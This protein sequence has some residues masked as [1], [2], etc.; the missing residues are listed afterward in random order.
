MC[1]NCNSLVCQ[2]CID[3]ISNSIQANNP[4]NLI[5]CIDCEQ[6]LNI[7][8]ITK[9]TQKGLDMLHVQ[10]P[11]NNINCFQEFEL[12]DILEHLETCKYYEG[13]SR[14]SGCGFIDWTNKVKNH[15]KVCIEFLDECKYCGEYFKKKALN[16]HEKTCYKRPRICKLCTCLID[17]ENIHLH[18]SKDACMLNFINEVKSQLESNIS[19][20]FIK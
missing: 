15:T 8:D 12:K 10:C 17:E 3:S 11:S 2:I 4:E 18:P 5:L 16:Q 19:P 7:S 6:V 14:C 20:F 13:K 1:R 9:I